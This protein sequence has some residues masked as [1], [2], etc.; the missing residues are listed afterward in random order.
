MN[1]EYTKPN[2]D[3]ENELRILAEI[4]ESAPLNWNPEY[5]IKEERLDHWLKMAEKYRAKCAEIGVHMRRHHKFIAL[6]II[7]PQKRLPAAHVAEEK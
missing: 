7:V 3:D 1:I 5:K 6:L 4:H 2:F